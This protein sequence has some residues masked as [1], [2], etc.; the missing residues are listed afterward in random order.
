VTNP[1]EPLKVFPVRLGVDGESCVISS[2]EHYSY[3]NE[4]ANKLYQ[5]M[6]GYKS[7]PGFDYYSSNHPQERDSFLTAL[8][9]DH[10]CS[11]HEFNEES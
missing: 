6:L 2:L 11:Q 3:L 5:L 4:K 1:T 9:L 10:W 7:Q 8:A